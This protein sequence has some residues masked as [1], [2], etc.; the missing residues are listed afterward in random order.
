MCNDDGCMTL[1]YVLIRREPLSRQIQEIFTTDGAWDHIIS[2]TFRR[3]NIPSH[4]SHRT[5]AYAPAIMHDM[6]LHALQ[7]SFLPVS[8]TCSPISSYR[9]GI[10]AR[11]KPGRSQC[12]RRHSH[13]AMLLILGGP[14][15][16]SGG[17]AQ[18]CQCA[19]I[20]SSLSIT[21]EL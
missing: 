5:T 4:Q 3:G 10:S 20:C 18:L 8:A 19:T 17:C 1:M 12:S 15:A 11:R 6:L 2:I 14:M 16:A 13:S 9:G 7:Q 21:P